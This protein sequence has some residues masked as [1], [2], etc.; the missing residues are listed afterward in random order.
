MSVYFITGGNRGIGIE[1]VKV[2]ISNEKNFIITTVRDLATSTE[3]NQ[4]KQMN[5]NLIVLEL[6]LFYEESIN[7]IPNKLDEFKISKI[8]VLILNAGI[9]EVDSMKPILETNYVSWMK[10]YRINTLSSVFLIKILNRFMIHSDT[11]K[12]I[13]LSSKLSLESDVSSSV[14][15]E[16]KASLN[17]AIYKLSRELPGFI[18]ILVHPGLVKTQMGNEF[19]NEILKSRPELKN[20]LDKITI[21]AKESSSFIIKIIGDLKKE[22]SGKFFNYDGEEIQ[23]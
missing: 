6:D 23:Y 20:S 21:T 7:A 2:L 9:G 18:L 17:H 3:L 10:Y 1:L 22:D 13:S 14:Y 19:I 5:N 8:D 15:G 4:L 16:S 11:R 12:I